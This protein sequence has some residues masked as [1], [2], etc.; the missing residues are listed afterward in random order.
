[1]SDPRRTDRFRDLDAQT[2][3]WVSFLDKQPPPPKPRF[4]L[5]DQLEQCACGGM[6][7]VRKFRLE[8]SGVVTYLDNICLD[9]PRKKELSEQWSIICATCKR[10]VGRNEPLVDVTGFSFRAGKVYHVE[11]C[12]VCVPDL[13]KSPIIEKLLYDRSCGRK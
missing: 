3:A 4:D 10:V 2:A 13:T 7:P 6:A 8:N 1:M 12:R 11:Q 9:C 5:L